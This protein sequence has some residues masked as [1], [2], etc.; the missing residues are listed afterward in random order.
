MLV[1]VYLSVGMIM[2]IIT[3]SILDSLRAFGDD[4][5]NWAPPA[6]LAQATG[7]DFFI[8]LRTEE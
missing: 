5:K 7:E 1:I 8:G 4:L 2:R 6:R 3:E